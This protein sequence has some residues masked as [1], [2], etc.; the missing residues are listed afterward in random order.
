MNYFFRLIVYLQTLT[1]LHQVKST[2][3]YVLLLFCLGLIMPIAAFATEKDPKNS[4]GKQEEFKEDSLVI[5]ADENKVSDP[6]ILEDQVSIS[7]QQAN[8][9]ETTKTYNPP[10][11]EKQEV[12]E[13]DPNAAMSFNFIYYIIDK[14]KLADPLD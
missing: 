12:R 7:Q 14:F 5:Y 4:E 10:T 1:Y 11:T 2:L 9:R 13:E 8:T 6:F 3:K